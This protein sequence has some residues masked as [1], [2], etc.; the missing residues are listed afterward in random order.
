M[1]KFS[2]I[3]DIGKSFENIEKCLNSIYQQTFKDYEVI[4]INHT[5]DNRVSR[6][7]ERYKDKLKLINEEN[8]TLADVRNMRIEKASGEYILYI[9]CNDYIEM[10][11]LSILDKCTKKKIDVVRFQIR[12]VNEKM[13]ENVIS[14][15]SFKTCCGNIALEHIA[16]YKYVEQAYMYLFNLEYIKENNYKFEN[17]LN[18]DFGLI[19]YIIYN[20]KSVISIGDILYNHLIDDVKTIKNYEDIKQEAYDTL[21]FS[22]QLLDKIQNNNININNYIVKQIILKS[23][24]LKGKDYKDILSQIKKYNIINIMSSNKINIKKLLCNIDVK[25]AARLIKW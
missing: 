8:L 1:A 12:D 19:P 16:K 5:S 6:I 13:K 11:T 4:A 10:N 15:I 14:E 9:N 18:S 22:V 25:L 17:K 21:Y 3:I 20:A 23:A 2:I 24:N 7:L